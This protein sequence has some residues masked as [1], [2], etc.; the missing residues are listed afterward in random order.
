MPCEPFQDALTEAA[1]TGAEPQGELCA[2]LKNCA[3]CQAAFELEQS[4]FAA[5]DSGMRIVANAE[6]PPSLLPS[7]RARLD[8]AGVPQRRW[9]SPVIFAAA[10]VVLAL[11]IFLATQP[12]QSGPDNQTKQT[13]QI[14]VS[15]TSLTNARRQNAGPDS[16]IVSSNMNNSQMPD[17]S[18]VLRPAASSEPEVLV[19]PDE[20][21]AFTRFVAILQMRGGVAVALVR[22]SADEKT[23]PAGLERLQIARLEV[24][25]LEGTESEASDGAKSIR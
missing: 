13:P 15:E 19:P 1:A 16:Q 12:R 4:L 17:H 20:R 3:A 6:V 22:P 2:H 8:E 23:E 18:T 14:P 9:M 21:E 24:K 5:I 25:P 11:A 10:S 7:V